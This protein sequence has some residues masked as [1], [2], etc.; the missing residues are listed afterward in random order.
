MRG[1]DSFS[2]HSWQMK[3]QAESQAQPD[4]LQRP[5]TNPAARPGQPRFMRR[6]FV[7]GLLAW[8][9]VWCLR[10]GESSTAG[11][12]SSAL[13]IRGLHLMAPNK[14]DVA[15]L[16]EDIRDS[17]PRAGVNTLILEFDY[18]FDFRSRPEFADPSA[19]GKEDVQRILKACRAS[20]IELIPEINCLGHQSWAGHNGRLLEKHPE[21]DET[22]GKYPNNEGI[23]CRSYCPLQPEVHEV[24]F[25]L[26]DELAAA[27]E[28]KSFH[29]GMDEVF[30]LADPDCPRC[31][32][33][34]AAQLFAGEVKTL[35]AHLEKIGC[36][37]WMWG[38]R[39]LDAESTG[40]GKWEASEN[41]TEPAIDLVPKDI[42]ICDWHYD[43]SPDTP[44]MFARKGFDVVV[45]PWR[46]SD[47]ALA[48]LAQVR[49]I[50]LGADQAAGRH[51]LGMVQTTWCGTSSFIKAQRMQ[52]SGDSAVKG[53]ASESASCFTI[54]FKAIREEDGG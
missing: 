10:A 50:R 7:A 24:L 19:P 25:D 2:S 28:A 12:P 52:L 5:Q 15:V 43:R 23:Y 39:F 48:E 26:I 49:T 46:K 22:P 21:F 8:A 51:M 44:R 32:G 16:V 31:K 37:M 38:D 11:H 14:R 13:P 42:V 1:P 40:L 27:C 41:G 54:L 6:L 53:S 20:G 36:R 33:K 47:V 45:C 17:L 3:H 9:G 35:H 34:G 4:A 18:H 29:V 30:I